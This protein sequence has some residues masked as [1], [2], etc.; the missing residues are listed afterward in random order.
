MSSIPKP[1]LLFTRP[2]LENS[3][4]YGTAL[5]TILATSDVTE[6]H[7]SM[8]AWRLGKGFAPVPHH[9]GPEDFYIIRGKLRFWVGEEELVAEAGDLVRTHPNMWHTFQVESDEAEFLTVFSPPGLEG[10]FLEL[11]SP[12]AAMELPAGRVG[13]PDINRLRELAPKYGIVFA[14]QGTT[15]RDIG[16][17]PEI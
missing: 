13:P 8:L 15:P 2:A 3:I 16:K 4:W 7:Y 12:A 17:L 10:F 9:H 5:I 1:T 14:A 6:G 11:G